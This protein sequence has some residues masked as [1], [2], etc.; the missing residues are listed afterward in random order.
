MPLDFAGDLHFI[1]ATDAL[2]EY[3]FKSFE[4]GKDIFR[5]LLSI[6]SQ[7]EF[8]DFVAEA[9]GAM[10]LKMKNDDVTL[11]ILKVPNHGGLNDDSFPP[12]VPNFQKYKDIKDSQSL[13]KPNG[14][15]ENI[16]KIDL[17]SDRLTIKKLTSENK[18][19]KRQ[20][21]ILGSLL[22]LTIFLFFYTIKSLDKTDETKS[23]DFIKND[24]IK[25]ITSYI[26][27]PQSKP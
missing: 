15:R 23:T 3:I 6:S 17:E 13:S 4:Q 26:V 19:L 8:E 5:I 14:E 25:K 18:A 20:R 27:I 16:S 7:A 12:F 24:F 9:R 22:I 10:D 2:S 1:L 11:V 21:F